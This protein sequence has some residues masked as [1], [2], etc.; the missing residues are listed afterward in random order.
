MGFPLRS[1]QRKSSRISDGDAVYYTYTIAPCNSIDNSLDFFIR[2]SIYNK[3]ASLYK[4][5]IITMRY[6][7]QSQVTKDRISRAMKQRYAQMSD[8]ERMAL[9]AKISNGQK[10][11]WQ[12][13]VDRPKE[14]TMDDY[15]GVGKVDDGH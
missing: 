6:K 11:S 3:G 10:R 5:G 9:N 2:L 15:L 1:F 4:R 12:N 14:I 13:A 7:T 8:S